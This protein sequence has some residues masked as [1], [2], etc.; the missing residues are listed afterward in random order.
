ML[1]DLVNDIIYYPYDDDRLDIVVIHR[2]HE[3]SLPANYVT[4]AFSQLKIAKKPHDIVPN[5]KYG[6]YHALLKA[7][8]RKL[9]DIEIVKEIPFDVCLVPRIFCKKEILPP[10]Y[11]STPMSRVRVYVLVDSR[12][13]SAINAACRHPGAIMCTELNTPHHSIKN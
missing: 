1:Y 10:R 7:I 12:Q 13:A 4:H 5:S 6:I 2:C 11:A 9:G 3:L 8:D